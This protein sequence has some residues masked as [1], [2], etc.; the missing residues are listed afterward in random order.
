MKKEKL[1][2]KYVNYISASEFSDIDDYNAEQ[3]LEDL[4]EEQHNRNRME[5]MMKLLTSQ[6]KKVM[7]YR[8]LEDLSLEEISNRLNI[9]YQSVQNILQRA[10]KTIKKHFSS[11]K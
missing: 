5:A 11:E 6:Q 1:H 8:Y 7:Q 3:Q 2:A 4:E 9:N 10:I